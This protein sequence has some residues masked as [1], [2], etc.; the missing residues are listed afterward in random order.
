MD[1]TTTSTG[2]T[3][4]RYSAEEQAAA[5]AALAE[6]NGNVDKTAAQLGIPHSTLRTWRDATVAVPDANIVTQQKLIRAVKWDQVQD[7]GVERALEALPT[8]SARDAAVVAGIAVDKAALLRGEAT[9]VVE[10]RDDAR[11]AAFRE[12]Y[13]KVRPVE[14]TDARDATPAEAEKAPKAL[15]NRG[16]GGGETG[17]TVGGER[18]SPPS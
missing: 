10:H 1:T 11:L 9:Q 16:E 7:M 4:T 6:N 12:R 3:W 13:A 5:L 8:A 14:L 15:G 17:G 18:L 2:K